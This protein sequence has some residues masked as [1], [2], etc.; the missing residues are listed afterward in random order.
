MS[1]IVRGVMEKSASIDITFVLDIT[2][3]MREF[4]HGIKDSLYKIL[5]E[6]INISNNR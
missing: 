4:V 5:S 6:L 2:Y 1:T 3:S